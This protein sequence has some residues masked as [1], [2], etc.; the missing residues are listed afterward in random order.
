VG[1]Y[2]AEQKRTILRILALCEE[3]E[4]RLGIKGH[5]IVTHRFETGM[6]GDDEMGDAKVSQ[7]TATTVAQWQY[8]QGK[9][10]WYLPVAATQNDDMLRLTALHEYVHLLSYAIYE[11]IPDKPFHD[12]LIELVTENVT[13]AICSATGG[14]PWTMESMGSEDE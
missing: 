5:W 7:T 8:R 9:M 6:D 13:R 12:K 3:I 10:R 2:N 11:L 14:E 1:V 4:T